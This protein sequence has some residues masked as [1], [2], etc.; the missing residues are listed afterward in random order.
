MMAHGGVRLERLI[1][2]ILCLSLA[3][4]CVR[5]GAD[6]PAL[7]GSRWTCFDQTDGL[8]GNRVRSLAPRADGGMWI[9]TARGLAL[10]D[11]QRL[12][13][14]AEGN[15]LR[16]GI[17]AIIEWAGAVWLGSWGDGLEPLI[18]GGDAWISD[19]AVTGDSLWVATYG[20]GLVQLTV[21]P[22]SRR[23]RE[24]A[25]R[26]AKGG[27][28]S[29]WLT[30]LLPDGAAL[31]IG[32][33]RAGLCYLDAQGEWHHHALP[34][35]HG[36]HVTALALADDGT[37]WVGT[38][39]GV[40]NWDI[41]REEYSSSPEI[42]LPDPHVTA[43]ATMDNGT[44][45]IGTDDGLVLWRDGR[46]T[47]FTQRD[48]LAHDAVSALALDA[49]GALWVGSGTRGLS[50]RAS[51]ETPAVERLPI[52]L[53]H[54]WRGPDSDRLED[55]EFQHLARWLREDG[56]DPHYV[57]GI[58]PE[59]PLH[60]NAQRLSEA[61]ERVCAET[62]ALQ[63]D[64]I[65]FSMGG[66]NTRAYIESTRYRGDVR[67]AFILGTPHRGEFL[68]RDLLLH[69]MLYWTREPSAIEL[70]PAHAR[71][72]N[73]THGN[74]AGV[75]YTL[76]AGDA[77]SPDLPTL[78]R[79][80]APGDGL[81]SAYS[82]LGTDDMVAVR[83]VTDDI[84]AWGDE[85][86]LL[87]LSTLLLPRT[88]Y[89]AHIRPQ[90]FAPRPSEYVAL[91]AVGNYVE[92]VP[93]SRTAMQRGSIR[94]GGMV[95][96]TPMPVDAEGRSR[97]QVRWKGL[98]LDVALRA[99]DGRVIDEGASHDADDVEFF[100]LGLADYA[101]F[102]I[103]DTA[104]GA[105]TMTLTGREGTLAGQYVA[106]AS[107]DTPLALVGLTERTWYDLGEPVAV[108]ASIEGADQAL[109]IERVRIEIHA[110]SRRVR[111]IT[112]AG[113]ADMAAATRDAGWRGTLSLTREGGYHVVLVTVSGRHGGQPYER[114][115]AQVIGVRGDRARFLGWPRVSGAGIEI[116]V[117]ARE[118]GEYLLSV[119][120][121]SDKTAVCAIAHPVALAAGRHIVTV[122][123]SAGLLRAASGDDGVVRI[124]RLVLADIAG[125]AIPLDEWH[126]IRVGGRG[127]K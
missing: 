20:H 26:R 9:G 95:T 114:Q 121:A 8:P 89:D 104:P 12:V 23:V 83:H 84:H 47:V 39:H 97:F 33:E 109:T 75:P 65:A 37:L 38:R 93:L 119:V 120:L 66:L 49:D 77:R 28:P 117:D 87:D 91:D 96:L 92:P 102:V 111:E 100:E 127:A 59:N 42:V 22:S 2:L 73:D 58:H 11:G 78:F 94:P 62:S 21:D 14:C 17:T 57:T 60:V 18:P 124:E 40:A 13:P 69:E 34:A 5:V 55:S 90:M 4:T 68:W 71:L 85:T 7:D 103:T 46:A 15:G 10:W 74:W 56:F 125:P 80:L 50:V 6:A 52:A 70:L 76:I 61:I 48:G 36:T 3:I 82:A 116:G 64:V 101:G 118:A 35:A 51:I 112:V 30:C 72:F 53:V 115:L 81:V 107:F 43:L 98:P 123:L 31:W 24:R 44:L 99:P 32:T 106:Y 79:E 63:V 67:R 16:G 110:P 45:W 108:A 41:R 86:I 25:H 88:T 27:L 1:P 54:G 113:A 126:D 122:P 29:D 19:L 105:W